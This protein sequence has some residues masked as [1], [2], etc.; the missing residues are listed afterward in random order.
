MA[1]VHGARSVVVVGPSDTLAVPPGIARAQES[2]P[3]GGPAAGIA[4]GLAEL[5]GS[6]AGHTVVLAC[7]MPAAAA[8]VEQ[9]LSAAAAFGDAEALM[10]ADAGKLQPLAALYRSDALRRAVRAAEA[11]AGVQGMSVFRLIA[12]LQV[13]PVQVNA[14]VTRDVDTWDD[15]RSFGIA[16]PADEVHLRGDE[17]SERFNQHS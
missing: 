16:Q 3:F 14:D 8:A 4:A 13:V 5:A 11:A 7:D 2:P 10:A 15:A 17:R 1:A 9:L 6:A 12:S